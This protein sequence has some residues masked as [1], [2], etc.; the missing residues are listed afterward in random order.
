MADPITVALVS[1]GS[2]AGSCLLTIF[3]TPWLQ[4]NLWRYQRRAGLR[5]K[6]AEDVNRIAAEFLVG[7]LNDEDHYRPDDRLFRTLARTMALVDALFSTEAA[8]ALKEMEVMIGPHLGP[9]G[10]GNIE[11][12]VQARDAALLALYREIIPLPGVKKS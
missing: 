1:A 5:L 7:Y 12:F 6:A 2:A 11:N 10:Q 9:S 4:H 8:R 3:L